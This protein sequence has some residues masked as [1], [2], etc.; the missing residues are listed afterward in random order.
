MCGFVFDSRLGGRFSV[1]DVLTSHGESIA[2]RGPDQIAW[3]STDD[4]FMFHARLIIKGDECHGTQPVLDSN[5]GISFVFNGEIF[6]HQQIAKRFDLGE[7]SSDTEFLK[8][9]LKEIG[10]RVFEW[11]DGIYAI[12][13]YNEDSVHLIRDFWGVKPLYYMTFEDGVVASSSEEFLARKFNLTKD[14]ASIACRN[15]MGHQLFLFSDYMGVEVVPPGEIITFSRNGELREEGVVKHD[16]EFFNQGTLEAA[17][18]ESVET[19]VEESCGISVGLSGGIDSGILW[20]ILK[21]RQDV[22]FISYLDPKEARLIKRRI[23]E[24]RKSLIVPED[25]IDEAD[26]KFKSIRRSGE[27]DGF[28]TLV[29]SMAARKLSTKVILSGLGADELFRGYSLSAPGIRLFIWR[30]FFGRP[31]FL[32]RSKFTRVLS[33]LGYRNLS[34]YFFSRGVIEDPSNLNAMSQLSSRLDLCIQSLNKRG[35]KPSSDLIYLHSQLLSQTDFYSSAEGIE[36]RVPF[37]SQYVIS[38]INRNLKFVFPLKLNLIG[39]FPSI[40]LKT[41][42]IKRGFSLYAK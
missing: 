3:V 6:N 32:R 1:G 33:S 34:Q 12:C 42:W 31:R 10:L 26:E 11:V 20:K 7:F 9:A 24:T 23:A 18:C 38:H 17:V 30:L 22:T 4:F 16:A 19:Q 14:P 25:L 41:S 15:T 39:A 5:S 37:L 13:I 21:D 8:V 2:R 29:L 28:N 27:T 40:L 35:F 36:V